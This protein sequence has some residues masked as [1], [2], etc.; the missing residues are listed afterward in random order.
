L[1]D[2]VSRDWHEVSTGRRRFSHVET[3][4]QSLL[5]V[6]RQDLLKLV[7][8]HLLSD[9]RRVL[10]TR[11]YAAGDDRDGTCDPDGWT[12]LRTRDE[13]RAWKERADYWPPAVRWDEGGVGAPAD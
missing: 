11:V 3:R 6:T 13:L 4:A 8:D 12:V 9:N 7:E 2:V 1:R 5:E 10:R